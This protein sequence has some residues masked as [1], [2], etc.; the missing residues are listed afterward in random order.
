[1]RAPIYYVRGGIGILGERGAPCAS[2]QTVAFALSRPYP[3]T[4]SS[5]SV[6]NYALM[7]FEKRFHEKSA[8]S[9]GFVD[10]R[11]SN[12]SL[13]SGHSTRRTAQ[14]FARTRESK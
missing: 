7:K 11:N 12:L 6:G 4:A 2:I 1:M 14:P 5:D 3:R 8:L 13:V 9:V 10:E